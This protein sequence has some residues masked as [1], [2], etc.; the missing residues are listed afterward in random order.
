M[1]PRLR[2]RD[3]SLCRNGS[4]G[5]V[6]AAVSLGVAAALAFLPVGAAAQSPATGQAVAAPAQPTYAELVELAS[7][8]DAVLRVAVT[9]Q[10]TVKA[11]RAPGLAA[12]MARLYLETATESLLAAPRAVGSSNAFL[13]DMPLTS[14]GKAPRLKDARYL[15]FADFVPGRAG[16]LQ[17][18]NPGAMLPADPVLEQRT[19]DVIRQ[20]A[21][22]GGVGALPTGIRDVI[23]IPGNLAGESETQMFIETGS[24]TPVSL[25][26]IRRPGM[27]PEWGVS[28]SEIVDQSASAPQPETLGWYRLACFL[29]QQLSRDAFLQDDPASR[30]RAIEDY[31]FVLNS[32]GPCS[33]R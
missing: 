17:L 25:S 21:D 6:S 14:R 23:S 2:F 5:T 22:A 18:V 32:L 7:A 31:D 15:I 12:G 10:A 8:A 33:R 24:G 13:V 19:A 1:N 16:E 20:L 29:P 3:R 11:E 9:D 27:A 26:V 28:W 30:S 4:N